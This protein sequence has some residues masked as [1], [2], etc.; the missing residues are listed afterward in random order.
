MYCGLTIY[1]RDRGQRLARERVPTAKLDDGCEGDC[2][3]FDDIVLLRLGR[4]F[5]VAGPMLPANLL[6]HTPSVVS[7]FGVAMISVLWAYEGWQFLG[8]NAGE[9]INAKRNFPLGLLISTATLVAF[10]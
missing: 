7:G 8:Y 3:S 10:D 4:G 5:R 1:S 2:H 6:Q 9:V